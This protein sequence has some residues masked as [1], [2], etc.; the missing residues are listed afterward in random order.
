MPSASLAPVVVI[1]YNRPDFAELVLAKIY[2]Y[3]PTKLYV[4]SDG[5]KDLGVDNELVAQTRRAVDKFD[6]DCQVVKVYSE[7]NLGLRERVLSGLDFVFHR[8]QSAIILEDDCMPSESFFEFVTAGLSFYQNNASVSLISGCS[9]HSP[10]KGVPEVYFTLDSPIWG[11]GT[12]RRAWTQFRSESFGQE[13]GRSEIKKISSTVQGVLAKRRFENL[14]RKSKDLD[15]WAIEFSAFNRSVG[16]LA[17]VSRVNLVE[18]IGFG[19]DS[20][21]TV[22]ESFADQSHASVLKSLP[23]FPSEVRRD[24]SVERRISRHRLAV[25]V[26]YPIKHPIDFILRVLRFLRLKSRRDKGWG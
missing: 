25:W 14:L 4:V 3:G 9:P 12:W 16:K 13:F 23:R 21:H 5:P 10:T 7:V 26:K 17:V 1:I 20:T 6:W 8:E 19:Q 15:S 2:D 24:E 18:N 22:F 11:W